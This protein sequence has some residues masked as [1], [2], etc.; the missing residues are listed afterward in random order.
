M[1]GE[2][3][4]VASWPGVISVVSCSYTTS[5]GISPGSATLT[6]LPQ[7]NFPD[8]TGTLVIGDGEGKIVLPDCK[9]DGL[10][11]QMGD[12]GFV[13]CL[14][15]VDRRWK[16]TGL[17][18]VSGNYNMLDPHAKLRPWS[19]QSP[20]EL[21][22]LCLDAMGETGYTID[23]PP[24]L[25]SDIGKDFGRRNPPWIG[26]IPVTGT[27]PPVVWTQD[28]PAQ[29]LQNLVEQFG[30]H[31]IYQWRTNSILIAIPGQ[32]SGGAGVT[33]SG[34]P[35]PDGSIA[36]ESPSISAP[37]TPSGVAVAGAPT[38]Y[39]GRF[40]LEAVGEDW[41]GSYRAINQLSYAPK[42]A[43]AKQ[44]NQALAFATNTNTF[45][46]YI[47]KP[48]FDTDPVFF[49]TTTG[50]A[51]TAVT[52][53]HNLINA[54]QDPRV[55]GVVIASISGDTLIVEGVKAGVEFRFGTQVEQP[56]LDEANF[57]AELLVAAVP[58]VPDWS[59]CVPPL[60]DGVRTTDRLTLVDAMRLAQKSVYR[61]YRLA[62]V[63]LS[64][65]GPIIVP[66]YGDLE[67]R[68]QLVLLP[69]KVD[70]ITPQPLDERLQDSS[71]QTIIRNFYGG[72]SRDM[73]AVCYGSVAVLRAAGGFAFWTPNFNSENSEPE[74]EI[75]VEFSIDPEEQIVTFANHVYKSSGSAFIPATPILETGVHVMNAK[76]NALECYQTARLLPGQSGNT[77]FAFR[78]YL[79]V[80]L[81]VIADYGTGN[82]VTRVR[83]LED[84]A[85]MRAGYYRDGLA[86]QYITAA[87]DTREYNG[88]VPIDL[89]GAI[90]QITWQIGGQGAT[91]TASANTE[92]ALWLPRY[93]ARRR[94]EFLAP[95]ETAR[96]VAPPM[97][98]PW[99]QANPYAPTP[100]QG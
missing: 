32:S 26:V 54:S 98:N 38:R 33:S 22:K 86:A 73:P 42:T 80:Q 74:D 9:I 17:G 2:R 58:S 67:R 63:G 41:D 83:L 97:V 50:T 30:R 99:L 70:Q 94:Q 8:E 93:P 85:V 16:W 31:V 14:R 28:P 61:N 53:L 19:I 64:G 57:A 36:R 91:T 52:N 34:G 25:T 88:I 6:I 4:G 47:G 100:P 37:E 77:N 44:K 59:Y 92:H 96:M 27:N 49:S 62:D 35:L 68:Q 79:D 10:S 29:A 60:F 11:V 23:L 71:G 56:V 81:N 18:Q 90:S 12:G 72:Y 55:K 39:Q 15:I 5:H 7:D 21:A 1:A 65:K 95:A 78:K 82:Q 20:T 84:D 45:T 48:G 51:S 75:L 13:W 3:H 87:A 40:R 43:G 46:A 89:D 76:T 69:T 24:G 66:G